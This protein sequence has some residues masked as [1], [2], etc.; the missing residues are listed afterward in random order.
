MFNCEI[1]SYII[2]ITQRKRH[3]NNACAYVRGGF[4]HVYHRTILTADTSAVHS[5]MYSKKQTF[6]EV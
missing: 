1:R 5:W 2:H 6:G 3:M 4:V